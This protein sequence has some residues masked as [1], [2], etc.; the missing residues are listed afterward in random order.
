MAG[1]RQIGFLRST[2]MRRIILSCIA[3]VCAF[4]AQAQ[5]V[6]YN[7][8]ETKLNQVTVME[9]GAGSLTPDA[10]YT[11][12]HKKY[13]ETAS[14]KNKLRYRTEA[15]A[16]AFLQ[17]QMADSVETSL[18]QRAKIEALNMADRKVDIAW[19]TEGPKIES[20]LK[21]FQDNIGRISSVDGGSSE[22]ERWEEYYNVFQTAIRSVR[23]SYLPN[24]ER[25]REYLRI[26]S[27]LCA[28]NE[29]LLSYIVMLNNRQ[30][31]SESLSSVLIMPGR[32]SEIAKEAG[33]RWKSMVTSNQITE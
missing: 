6:T 16:S 23:E 14:S 25:K 24:S 28:Q 7:H 5:Y 9:T 33:S 12:L 2:T 3:A 19:Q 27:D 8:S 30:S 29:T 10:Y 1:G 31:T 18:S 15:G 32:K 11:L 26:Y 20:K 21:A 13:S 17:T 4:S 22:K